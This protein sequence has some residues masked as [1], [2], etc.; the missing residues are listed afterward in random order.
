MEDGGAAM[1]MG[2]GAG[3]GVEVWDDSSLD[4]SL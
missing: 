1:A 4:S 2:V 3:V